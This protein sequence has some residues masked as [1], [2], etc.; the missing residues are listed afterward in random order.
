MRRS[1]IIAEHIDG[2]TPI[3]ERE[4]ILKRLDA[5]EVDLVSNCMVLTEGWD[6]PQVSCIILARPTKSIGLYRQMVGRGLRPASNKTDLLI[7]DH[8]GAVFEHGLPED[9]VEW[10]LYEDARAT[11]QA[12]ASRGIGDRRKLVECPECSAVRLQGHPCVVCGW[13]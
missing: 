7:I 4:D 13:R 10:P 11:N 3:E 9:P 2:S 12:Q 1:G 6:Q 8:A 5:G